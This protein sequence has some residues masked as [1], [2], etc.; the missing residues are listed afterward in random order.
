M[1]TLG[2]QLQAKNEQKQQGRVTRTQRVQ[3]QQQTA[4]ERQAFSN[5]QSQANALAGTL[6][7]PV[8][9]QDT[10]S[11]VSGYRPASISASEWNSM[12]ASGKAYQ[13]KLMNSGMSIDWK[14]RH[15]EVVPHSYA[16]REVT[17]TREY[18]NVD[19]GGFVE[20]LSPDLKKFFVTKPELEKQQSDWRTGEKVKTQLEITT[21]RRKVTE[22]E[23]RFKKKIASKKDW[24]KNQTAKYRSD[25]KNKANYK[26]SLDR[27]RSNLEEQQ[28]YYKGFVE[29][30]TLGVRE[31][32]KGNMFSFSSIKEGAVDY[33]SYLETKQESKTQTKLTNLKQQIKGLVPIYNKNKKISGWID[34]SVERPKYISDKGLTVTGEYG[35]GYDVTS[36]KAYSSAQGYAGKKGFENLPQS[37]QAILNPSAIQWQTDNPTEV[38]K[39]DKTGNV[40]GVKSELLGGAEVSLEQYNDKKTWQDYNYN[41]WEK[42][43]KK[44]IVPFS[45]LEGNDISKNYYSQQTTMMDASGNAMYPPIIVSDSVITRDAPNFAGD[46]MGNIMKKYS[47]FIGKTGDISIPLSLGISKIIKPLN[48]PLITMSGGKFNPLFVG[49]DKEIKVKDIT[50]PLK[51]KLFGDTGFFTEQKQ[52]LVKKDLEK[53]GIQE[54]YLT[55][56][57]E[58]YQGI[59]QAEFDNEYRKKLIYEEITFEDAVAEFEKSDRAK[60]VGKKY[61][62]EYGK[63]YDK[64]RASFGVDN[65]V[66]G[67]FPK[68]SKEQWSLLGLQTGESLSK[69]A[70]GVIPETYGEAG[71][72]TALIYSGSKLLK[73]YKAIPTSIKNVG[74][75]SYGGYGGVQYLNPISSPE[76]KAMGLINFASSTAILGYSGLRYAKAPKITRKVIN[77][78]KRTTVT[79]AMGVEKKSFLIK[80]HDDTKKIET[81]FYGKQKLGQYG[82]KGSRAEVTTNWR[83]WSNKYL[84]TDLKPIYYGVPTQQLGTSYIVQG[85]RGTT[86][87]NVTPSA[88]Q[89]ARNLLI[90]YGYTPSQAT[91]TLRY[92]APKVIYQYLEGGRILVS[93]NKAIGSFD[94]ITKQPV[95]DVDKGLGIKT[96]GA[97]PKRDTYNFGREVVGTTK[98]GDFVILESGTKTRWNFITKEGT[99]YNLLTG[100]TKT[101]YTQLSAVKVGNI[102]DALI[103]T[104]QE[105]IYLSQKQQIISSTFVKKQLVPF[106]RKMEMGKSGSY[107]YKY[108]GGGELPVLDLDKIIKAN[109]GFSVSKASSYSINPANIKKTPFSTTFGKT[110]DVADIKNLVRN[111]IDNKASPIIPKSIENSFMSQSQYSGLGLYE[112][113]NEVS[114]ALK[115]SNAPQID[116]G[117]I[118]R[119]S[120]IS[121]ANTN[122]LLGV[123]LLSTNVVTS[124][125][126]NLKLENQLKNQLK[127][128][129]GLKQ[130]LGLKSEIKQL[131]SLKQGSAQKSAMNNIFA[132]TPII[133]NDFITPNISS[134]PPVFVNPPIIPFIIDMGLKTAK[135]RKGKRK[136]KIPEIQGLFPDFTSRAIGLAPK[137]VSGVEGALKEIR[138]LQTGFEIRRGARLPVSKN[139]NDVGFS[140]INEKKLMRGIMK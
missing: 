99:P 102:N 78:P 127:L 15:G 53:T 41:K 49:V 26:A 94:Y 126:T 83:F 54:E 17:K 68:I 58:K 140:G 69:I 61:S 21:A 44:L 6:W 33:G 13:I 45:L 81:V 104:S 11:Y 70:I 48:I 120:T 56:L 115:F 2:Q 51:E 108:Q 55:P 19:Y 131:S 119:P 128:N 137:R 10:E 31:L 4:K 67:V 36:F 138:K 124:L 38:L 9:Y 8:E 98:S 32:D 65:K 23:E 46:F 50:T 91:N 103:P 25:Q 66:L 76:K 22:E 18:T 5:Q 43:E 59:S 132:T 28:Q 85:F 74:I 63:I 95:L 52:K 29:K 121:I 77:P 86:T 47:S 57:Q 100:K 93:G 75:A 34:P 96:R 109:T 122:S 20:N 79:D 35:R 111:I 90:K 16:T 30:L 3:Y 113:T 12:S 133:Q 92:V 135:K 42:E 73:G 123:G 80:L 62:Y 105:N 72:N 88:Y 106:I 107:L 117:N 129:L 27:L 14:I 60:E 97:T 101:F 24:W 7:Q 1:A 89:Q 114:G 136:R 64:E 84:K 37:Q 87:V 139:P 110:D 71:V 39:F 134:P 118:F 82:L 130:N 112:R 116:I 125:K 40:I